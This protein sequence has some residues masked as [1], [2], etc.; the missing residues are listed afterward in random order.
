MTIPGLPGWAKPD[1]YPPPVPATPVLELDRAQELAAVPPA[2]GYG[3][4]WNWE[5]FMGTGLIPGVPVTLPSGQVVIPRADGTLAPAGEPRPGLTWVQTATGGLWIKTD[6]P[7]GVPLIQGQPNGDLLV[8]PL[9]HPSVAGQAGVY[10]DDAATLNAAAIQAGG[11]YGFGGRVIT[12]PW[13][14]NLQSP[15]V[16]PQQSTF[17]SN[18]VAAGGPVS[19]AGIHGA[20][21][22]K[23]NFTGTCV[24]AHRSQGYGLQ[25][26]ITAQLPAGRIEGVMIDMTGAGP[27]SIGWDIGDG[28]WLDADLW[29]AN[30]SAQPAV[31]FTSVGNFFTMP[32]GVPAPAAGFPLMLLSGS[33]AT[34]FQFGLV[35]YVVNPTATTFQLALQPGG[36]VQTGT[37]NAGQITVSGCVG[38]HYT[39]QAFYN[40]KQRVRCHSMH[41]AIA[42]L[43]DTMVPAQAVSQEYNERDFTIFCDSGQA[44]VVLATGVNCNGRILYIQGNMAN[45]ASTGSVPTANLAALTLCGSN[46][47][48]TNTRLYSTELRMKVEANQGNGPSNGT[49]PY[50][51]YSDGLGYIKQL[52]GHIDGSN[53]T[54]SVL[55]GAEC[56]FEGSINQD[57]GL[58]A[59]LTSGAVFAMGNTNPNGLVVVG[60][61]SGQGTVMSV[62]NNGT[63][64]TGPPVL[65]QGA[66]GGDHL[67]GA[68]AVGD[69]N[70]RWKVDVGGDT[71]WGPGSTDTDV[72][73]GRNAAGVLQ[74]GGGTLGT[75]DVGL[76]ISGSAQ[77]YLG[78]AEGAKPA[79]PTGGGRLYVGAT[80][81]LFYLSPGGTNTQI[82][83]P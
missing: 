40:E 69:S 77:S 39:A 68:Q 50:V 14:Y 7:P 56:D 31:T 15:F 25:F 52:S 38:L 41:N 17:T 61:V 11:S 37:F 49:P 66:E 20:T 24:Y 67:L 10:T 73:L 27:G 48:G 30:G 82:G 33:I 47:S 71:K 36:T 44:G 64:P 45:T 79:T 12:G 23:Q 4:E 59:A 78:I 34:G 21:V 74:V 51:I 57:P 83:P 5:K 76:N 9:T 29:V 54:A 6:P 43:E 53:L 3:S 2:P 62:T 18:G 58:L 28:W 1:S 35:Y 60:S 80:G 26:G 81:A 16:L 42:I 72:D 63:T 65:F 55:N 46:G 22:F 70:P 19:L 13:H 32:A 75:A 8:L